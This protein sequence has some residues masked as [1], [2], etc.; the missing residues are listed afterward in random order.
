MAVKATCLVGLDVHARQTHAAVLDLR[1]GEVA[2]RRLV[3]APEEVVALLERLPGPVVAVYE[4]GP[5]GFGL[6]R[7]AGVRGIDVRV[8]APGSI[9]RDRA[10]GSRPIGVTRSGWCGCWPQASCGSRSSR[11][12]RTRRFGI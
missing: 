5:T 6:A 4:A 2:V 9:P 7:N 10:T 12:S 1:S 8:V 11:A 3:G